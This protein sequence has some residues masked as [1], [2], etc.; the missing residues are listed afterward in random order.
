DTVLVVENPPLSLNEMHSVKLIAYRKGKPYVSNEKEALYFQVGEPLAEYI[1]DFD[2]TDDADFAGSGF[3]M[4]QPEGCGNAAIHSLHS[5]P[6]GVG[7]TGNELI[8]D[9]YLRHPIVIN[10]G[11]SKIKYR[12]IALIEP[13]E[14]LSFASETFFDY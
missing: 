1:N 2:N 3:S 4:V 13:G 8:F 5:Y 11:L 10:K 12:D 6:A 7:I 14:S 9:Y